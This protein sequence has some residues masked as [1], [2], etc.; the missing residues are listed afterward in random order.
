MDI[1]LAL[2]HWAHMLGL[3]L[4]IGSLTMPLHVLRGGRA[5]P[6]D[7]GMLERARA[8]ARV[9][10]LWAVVAL[11]VTLAIDVCVTALTLTRGDAAA[12][13]SAVGLRALLF[14]SRYGLAS[15]ARWL[16][17]VVSLWAAGEFGRAR[18]DA[19]LRTPRPNRQALGIVAPVWRPRAMLSR[20]AWVRV[21]AILAVGVLLGAVAAGPDGATPLTTAIAALRLAATILWLGGTIALA[22]TV[23][24]SMSLVEDGRRPMALLTRLNRFT[25][26]A[27]LSIVFLVATGLWEA[28]RAGSVAPRPGMASGMSLLTGVANA[29]VFIKMAL[30]LVIVVVSAWSLLGP[31]RRLQQVALRARRDPS[32]TARRAALLRIVR[33]AV[34]GA[35]MLAALALL[36]GALADLYPRQGQALATAAT[37]GLRDPRVAAAHAGTTT[38]LLR[39]APIGIASGGSAASII[40]IALSDAAGAPVSATTVTVTARSLDARAVVAPSVTALNVGVGRYRA[41][42]PLPGGG[43]WRLTVGVQRGARGATALFAL[44]APTPAAS[45]T[46]TVTPRAAPQVYGW[47]GVGPVLITHALVSAPDN[48]ALLYEGTVEGVYRSTDGGAHWTAASD[49]LSDAAREVWSLTFLPDRSLV[50]ATGGGLYRS[51]DGRTHWRAA[52][53]QT[54]A[55]YTLAAHLTGH[56][57]LLAGGDGGVYRAD[58]IEAGAGAGAGAGDARWRQVYDSGATA[59][60]SLAWPAARPALVVAGVNPGSGPRGPRPVIMSDDGGASWMARARGLPIGAGALSIAVAP[61]AR[62]VY[63]GTLD[64]GAYITAVTQENAVWQGRGVG[65]PAGAQV[66]SFA[67]DPTRPTLLYAATAAG[68]YRSTDG[69]AHWSIFGAGL[70]GDATVVT[71]LALVSGPRPVLYAATAAGLYRYGVESWK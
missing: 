47:H 35:A 8:R 41:R 42:L 58:N 21:S 68:V 46:A 61:G 55:I 54:R 28:A 48:H 12:A 13:F 53:L 18:A 52:G 36:C 69:G 59:V 62:V 51:I 66:N 32:L 9:V 45:S 3:A 2:V 39:V 50:A 65:L 56:I 14:G 25:P 37:T 64:A 5:R 71:A 38:V 15:V 63:L 22:I 16:L 10:A 7:V 17:L 26:I 67:F 43:R 44:T 1:L 57:V 6:E 70:S 49:G 40:D 23:V 29:A 30:L 27:L 60:T 33:R 24:P 11:L 34:T 19:P 20:D 4:W 31:R